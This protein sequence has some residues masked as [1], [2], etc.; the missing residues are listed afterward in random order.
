MHHLHKG[1]INQELAGCAIRWKPSKRKKEKDLNAEGGA[2]DWGKQCAGRETVQA[3]AGAERQ[4]ILTA[5][6]FKLLLN[7]SK[8][9]FQHPWAFVLQICQPQLHSVSFQDEGNASKTRIVFIFFFLCTVNIQSTDR[10]IY[11]QFGTHGSVQKKKKKKN[12]IKRSAGWQV[13]TSTV[14]ALNFK[15]L[16]KR[17]KGNEK[18]RLKQHIN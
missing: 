9:F 5:N 18:G 17:T 16:D 4:P 15:P 7:C 3:Y 2:S 1:G 14:W 13:S 6:C 8:K 10:G 11:I 12:H